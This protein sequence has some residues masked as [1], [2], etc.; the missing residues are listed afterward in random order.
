MLTVSVPPL[1]SPL[2]GAALGA[3]QFAGRFERVTEPVPSE[4]G[5]PVASYAPLAFEGTAGS[6][7]PPW[8]VTVTPTPAS[9]PPRLLLIVPVI[10]PTP[11]L[12]HVSAIS[13]FTVLPPVPA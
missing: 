11:E 5:T 3:V 8:G 12:E 9:V 13:T 4:T 6:A 7:S 2:Y 1:A 10:A